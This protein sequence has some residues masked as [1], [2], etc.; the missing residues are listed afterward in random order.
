MPVNT[1]EGGRVSQL[2]V[3]THTRRALQM[4]ENGKGGLDMI[5]QGR[6]LER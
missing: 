4:L 6:E 2:K 5:C 1:Q 3:T